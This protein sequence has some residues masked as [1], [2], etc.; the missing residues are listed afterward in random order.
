VGYLQRLVQV[1]PQEQEA[2]ELL[3]LLLPQLG[4][5]APGMPGPSVEP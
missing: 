1:S 2:R 5:A 4:R 3:R